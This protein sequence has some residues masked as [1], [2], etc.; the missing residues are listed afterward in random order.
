[1]TKISFRIAS[2]EL[3]DSELNKINKDNL[4]GIKLIQMPQKSSDEYIVN[5]ENNLQNFDHEFYIENHF[6]KVE[7]VIMM[8]RSVQSCLF[9]FNQSTKDEQING[10]IERNDENCDENVQQDN[11]ETK[12][13]ENKNQNIIGY[14]T[15]DMTKMEKGVNNTFTADIFS[16]HE[17]K[18][19]GH[20]NFEIYIMNT[21]SKV[22]KINKETV[23]SKNTIRSRHIVQPF[24]L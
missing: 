2:I 9:N 22:Y 12:K 18:I 4:F 16:K 21:P 17:D 15:I 8:I 10:T 11:N 20:A 7:K 24:V 13:I 3:K 19:V 1:M 6:N 23:I 5:S 14:C